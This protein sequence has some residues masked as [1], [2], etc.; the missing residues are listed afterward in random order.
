MNPDTH[1]V[2][3]DQPSSDLLDLAHLRSLVQENAESDPRYS[4]TVQDI[5]RILAAVEN[6]NTVAHALAAHDMDDYSATI[7]D[8]IN[9]RVQPDDDGEINWSQMD[10]D[11]EDLFGISFGEEHDGELF[12]RLRISIPTLIRDAHP[13]L[14]A[15]ATIAISELD[16]KCH[17]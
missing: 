2:V 1:Y 14:M 3:V 17:Q 12:L 4:A 15:V 8:L 11:P 7:V 9:E 5:K 6:F 16:L 10:S 13:K